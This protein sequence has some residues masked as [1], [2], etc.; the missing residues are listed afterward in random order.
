MAYQC[1]KCHNTRCE[2]DEIR[3]SG[4]F[5]SKIFDVQNKRFTTVS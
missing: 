4:G 5:L 1:A 3:T 2:M